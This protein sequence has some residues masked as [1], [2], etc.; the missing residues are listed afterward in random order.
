MVAPSGWVMKTSSFA[1][2]PVAP[3]VWITVGSSTTTVSLCVMPVAV[4][5]TTTLIS[6]GLLTSPFVPVAHD[7]EYEPS[8]KYSTAGCEPDGAIAAV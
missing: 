2:E 6:C 5:V 8:L 1:V 4:S 7:V 3:V